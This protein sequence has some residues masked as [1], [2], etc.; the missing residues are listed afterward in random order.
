MYIYM[1]LHYIY[2]VEYTR[3]SL[4]A[5]DGVEGSDYVNANYVQVDKY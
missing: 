2:T 4:H 5:I 1:N 3:V